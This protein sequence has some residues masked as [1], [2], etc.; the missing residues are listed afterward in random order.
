MTSIY[1]A[2][3]RPVGLKITQF[4][5]LRA[6]ERLG[7]ATYGEIAEEAALDQTTIS[8]NLKILINAGWV[9]VSVDPEQDARFR[10]ARLSKEGVKKLRSAE[11]YW[12]VAQR[13]V[14]GGVQ[15]FL[16]GPANKQL[17]EALE[18]LQRVA[19]K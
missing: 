3:L 19:I 13:R 11:P 8:R 10:L 12:S 2:A 14:E 7:K 15:G 9:S 18:T 4:S 5:L 16:N 17:L 6:L 1:D